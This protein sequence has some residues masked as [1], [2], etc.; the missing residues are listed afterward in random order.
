MNAPESRG[1]AGIARYAPLPP[2]PVSLVE[3]GVGA[4]ADA[5]ASSVSTGPIG[6]TGPEVAPQPPPGPIPPPLARR[7]AHRWLPARR[8]PLATGA[9]EALQ[10]LK[11][12]QPYAR[13]VSEAVDRLTTQRDRARML[14][15]Y[16]EL[17]PVE[18]AQSTASYWDHGSPANPSV[19][20]SDAEW[21]FIELVDQ[22]VVPLN[23]DRL[24]EEERFS[25]L[26]V[27][28]YSL[29]DVLW[30]GEGIDEL[31]LEYRVLLA[32]IGEIDVRYLDEPDET[33]AANAGE[34]GEAGEAP[35]SA[36]S[37]SLRAV[38]R[39]CHDLPSVNGSPLEQLQTLCA[40]Q[41]APLCHF[42]D[43]CLYVHQETGNPLLDVSSQTYDDDPFDWTRE[44][45]DVAARLAKEALQTLTNVDTFAAWLLADV[46]AGD[47]TGS[48]SR[49]VASLWI[50]AHLQASLQRDRMWG[51]WR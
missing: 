26:P 27:Q 28:D 13:Q 48:A 44:D 11:R 33:T 46:D 23:L 17:F 36:L 18:F 25:I 45:I 39:L 49:K 2:T 47:G 38:I 30:E 34:V 4:P 24:W 29:W 31:R 41:P 1:S 10:R 6:R 43:A 32:V 51:S 50:R 40:S 37:P 9:Q 5:L 14:A 21:E 8:W 16:R 19:I 3:V 22:R 7:A 20:Y 15:L 12:Y 35:S 42:A